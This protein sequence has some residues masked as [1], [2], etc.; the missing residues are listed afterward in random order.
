MSLFVADHQYRVSA[1]TQT[2]HDDAA[3]PVKAFEA[4]L[5]SPEADGEQVRDEL[6]VH[7]KAVQNAKARLKE[8]ELQMKQIEAQKEQLI[9]QQQQQQQQQRNALLGASAIFTSSTVQP[10]ANQL[11]ALNR[12]LEVLKADDVKLLAE[13]AIEINEV[14]RLSE[15][16]QAL[17]G[18]LLD[19]RLAGPAPPVPR[20]PMPRLFAFVPVST[21]CVPRPHAMVRVCSWPRWFG[22]I[23]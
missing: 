10:L 18:K 9:T 16:L 8:L 12:Q 14:K 15:R 13:L 4:S 20:A 17:H 7:K 21:L 23:A 5:Q 3:D 22:G 2:T 11:Q 1:A 19:L 6:D